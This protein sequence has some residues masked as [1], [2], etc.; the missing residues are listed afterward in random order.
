MLLGDTEL[1]HRMW[2]APEAGGGGEPACAGSVP[3]AGTQVQRSQ[4]SH[5]DTF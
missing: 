4:V 5:L 3:A 1:L 2:Q